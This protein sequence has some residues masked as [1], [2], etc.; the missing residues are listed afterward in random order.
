MKTPRKKGSRELE[1]LLASGPLTDTGRQADVQPAAGDHSAGR[2]RRARAT[3]DT[4]AS[5]FEIS[6]NGGATAGEQIEDAEGMVEN[7]EA[8]KK[9]R[10]LDQLMRETRGKTAE[11]SIKIAR[12]RGL[13]LHSP[14]P[15]KRTQQK[16][17]DET[18]DVDEGSD[19]SDEEMDGVD[20]TSNDLDQDSDD[21]VI[22]LDNAENSPDLLTSK[23][24]GRGRGGGRGGGRRSNHCLSRDWLL[25]YAQREESKGAGNI[26]THHCCTADT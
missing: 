26:S 13:A 21:D 10:K 3:K 12:I 20:E 18:D 22:E 16:E 11:T 1:A 7:C 23:G 24:S 25:Q 2:S 15:A 6:Q 14:S 9:G 19:E 4:A 17:E 5:E 8:S